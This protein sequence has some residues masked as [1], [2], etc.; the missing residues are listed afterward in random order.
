MKVALTSS[1]HDSQSVYNQ[2]R[3]LSVNVNESQQKYNHHLAER[4]YQ[5]ENLRTEQKQIIVILLALKL[6]RSL[7]GDFSRNTMRRF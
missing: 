6:W 3:Q 5:I 7:F 1:N 2:L 4:D